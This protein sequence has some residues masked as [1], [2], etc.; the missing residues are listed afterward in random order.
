MHNLTESYSVWFFKWLYHVFSWY[1]LIQWSYFKS[2]HKYMTTHDDLCRFNWR[3]V[4]SD[5]SSWLVFM[6]WHEIWP[7]VGFQVSLKDF[8]CSTWSPVIPSVDWKSLKLKQ[9]TFQC[10]TPQNTNDRNLP[11]TWRPWV[12][13]LIYGWWHYSTLILI[14]HPWKELFLKRIIFTAELFQT[15]IK[16]S[17]WLIHFHWKLPHQICNTDGKNQKSNVKK[18]IVL[19][20]EN[21]KTWQLVRILYT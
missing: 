10:K 2:L 13:N 14:S 3:Q 16:I 11:W 21:A 8:Q 7:F 6:W 5:G 12:T 1:V 17:P 18:K 4:Y 19:T 15:F 9:V 20:T